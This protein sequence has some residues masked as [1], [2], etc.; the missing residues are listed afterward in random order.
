MKQ[1]AIC[2]QAKEQGTE[3]GNTN[4]GVKETITA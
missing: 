1:P 3:V 4:G 2:F